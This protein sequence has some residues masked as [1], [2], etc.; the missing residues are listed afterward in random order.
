MPRLTSHDRLQSKHRQVSGICGNSEV[1]VQDASARP[2]SASHPGPACCSSQSCHCWSSQ[3]NVQTCKHAKA[4]IINFTVTIIILNK[5]GACLSFRLHVFI[6]LCLLN[7]LGSCG[8]S[9]IDSG[10]SPAV[11][12]LDI[13]KTFLSF[14]LLFFPLLVSV[15]APLVLVLQ[16]LDIFS[17]L[18]SLQ[19]FS[20]HFKVLCTYLKGRAMHRE[21]H[22]HTHSG[23]EKCSI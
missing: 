2:G 4:S 3:I 11:I 10:N 23:R 16:I 8:V 7:L 17:S 18:L 14:S 6:L 15:T 21:G 13:T 5:L 19:A 22:T 9:V 1:T 20:F 12:A